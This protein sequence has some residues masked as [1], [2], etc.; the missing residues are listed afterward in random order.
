MKFSNEQCLAR[1]DGSARCKAALH[2]I[3]ENEL[4]T[5]GTCNGSGSV[6]GRKCA[7][8]VGY[9]VEFIGKRF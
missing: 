7:A 9:G 2:G 4:I 8:C 6:D 1:L 3:L 5:C